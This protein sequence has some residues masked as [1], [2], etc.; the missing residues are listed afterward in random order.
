MMN[1][2]EQRMCEM[3]GEFFELSVERFKCSSYKFISRFM[4][5]DIAKRLD[6]TDDPYN[7]ISPNN[8]IASMKN[9]YPSLN[10]E[11]GEK[12][13][14]KVIRWVGYI[15]RAYSIIKKRD[16]SSIYKSIKAQQMV[17]LYDSFHTFSPEYCVDRLED[18]VNENNQTILNDYEVFRQIY[19]SN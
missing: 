3:Q 15:Y 17:A 11:N 7:F 2:H 14:A 6:E 1:N 10:E 8:L 13:S 18:I 19:E 4:N 12:L 5:S 9:N 16:S